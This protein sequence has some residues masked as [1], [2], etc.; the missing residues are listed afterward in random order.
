MPNLVSIGLAGNSRGQR[1]MA[2]AVT[3][4]V[5]GRARL[6]IVQ[7]QKSFLW[8]LKFFCDFDVLGVKKHEESEFGTGLNLNWLDCILF[9]HFQ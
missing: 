4:S 2:T 5:L 9:R 7:A 3:A 8:V 1:R 6:S